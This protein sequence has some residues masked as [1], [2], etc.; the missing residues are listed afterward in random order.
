MGTVVLSHC[1]RLAPALASGVRGMHTG[2][3][4]LVAEGQRVVTSVAV[5]VAAELGVCESTLGNWDKRRITS[6]A[7]TARC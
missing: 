2:Y 4:L 5:G 6:A 3:R 7:A 1:V